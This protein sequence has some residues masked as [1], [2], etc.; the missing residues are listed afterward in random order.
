MVQGKRMD[1]EYF[2]RRIDPVLAELVA[3]F[4]AVTVTG[5]RAVGKT[6]SAGRLAGEVVRLDRPDEAGLFAA[7]PAW[8]F[9]TASSR[10][11]WTSGKRWAPSLVPSSESRPA[12]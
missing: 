11:C 7:D 6:T 4:P 3:R 8:R 5:P 10:C 1:R 9:A 12:A 2:P